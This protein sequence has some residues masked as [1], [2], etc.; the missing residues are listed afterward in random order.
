MNFAGV[1]FTSDQHFF[2]KNIIEYSGRPFSDVE[3][4]NEAMI[5]RFNAKV[6]DNGR[7]Y[8]LGDFA[9][10]DKHVAPILRR[11]NGIHYLVSGNHDGCHP[12]HEDAGAVRRF[13]GYG[14]SSVDE[15]LTLD[16]PIGKTLLCHMPLK[17][18]ADPLEDRRNN[19]KYTAYRPELEDAQ[20]LLHGH[21]HERWKRRGDMINVGVDQWDF[22][23]VSV[24]EICALVA[25]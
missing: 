12:I 16:L 22:T 10:G 1:F 25:T 23:P 17:L 13:L 20:Y 4:M 7:T 2:H 21:V 6:P 5:D 9:W 11:L 18:A 19:D 3:E 15:R 24:E 8:H 14:F